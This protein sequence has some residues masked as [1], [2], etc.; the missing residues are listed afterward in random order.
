[1]SLGDEGATGV[2]RDDDDLLD[3][4]AFDPMQAGT[5]FRVHPATL[6]GLGTVD[7]LSA[8]PRSAARLAV[9]RQRVA[10]A[11]LVGMFYVTNVAAGALFEALFRAASISPGRGVA[12]PRRDLANQCLSLVTLREDL[13]VIPLGLPGRRMVVTDPQRDARWREIINTPD[14]SDTHVPA[15]AVYR[16]VSSAGQVHPGYS[17]PSIQEPRAMVYLLYD[18]PHRRDGWRVDQT[19]ALD[20]AAGEAFIAQAL[21]DIGFAW[22]GD[23]TGDGFTPTDEEE[24]QA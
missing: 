8:N 10:S 9:Q 15:V 22:L 24:A 18:P 7:P 16:Q 5:Y 1:M 13:A 20:T 11:P 4:I 14:H 3:A 2:A 19:I 21:A 6:P 23:P 17:W 12:F